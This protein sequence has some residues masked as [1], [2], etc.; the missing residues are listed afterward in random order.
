MQICSFQVVSDI[1][2]VGKKKK[3]SFDLSA[4]TLFSL[5]SLFRNGLKTSGFMSQFDSFAVGDV[6][7]ESGGRAVGHL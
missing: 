6:W 3:K 4:T 7:D 5:S 2:S 1:D